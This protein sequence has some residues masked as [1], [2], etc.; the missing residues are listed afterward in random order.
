MF[1][2]YIYCIL[3]FEFLEG[4]WELK[5]F[6]LVGKIAVT[7]VDS[8]LRALQYLGLDD[9]RMQSQSDGFVVCI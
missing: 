2:F 1:Y 8:G 5:I 9:H 4:A 6:G 3:F 7:A